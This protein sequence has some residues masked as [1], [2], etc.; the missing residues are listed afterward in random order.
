[1]FYFEV[2]V[3]EN[4]ELGTG[5]LEFE[6]SEGKTISDLL[7]DYAMS[8]MKE[9]ELQEARLAKLVAEDHEPQQD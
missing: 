9:R 4:P 8:Y 7:T 3:E 6:T 5:S 2:S 1:M